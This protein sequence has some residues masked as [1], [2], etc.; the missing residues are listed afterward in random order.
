MDYDPAPSPS[1]D[2]TDAEFRQRSRGWF[3][4]YANVDDTIGFHRRCWVECP[5]ILG[6]QQHGD[7]FTGDGPRQLAYPAT[8]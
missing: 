1:D 8:P 2:A 5:S 7:D 6:V 4:R 3:D